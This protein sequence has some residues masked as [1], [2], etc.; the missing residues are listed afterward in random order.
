MSLSTKDTA[1]FSVIENTGQ[2]ISQGESNQGEVFT[3]TYNLIV[4]SGPPTWSPRPEPEL[5][6]VVLNNK[7]LGTRFNNSY[8]KIIEDYRVWYLKH[9][10]GRTVKQA[11]EFLRTN[12]ADIENF[13]CTAD[14]IMCSD[15]NYDK[16]GFVRTK[17]ITAKINSSANGS[18]GSTFVLDG[19][20]VTVRTA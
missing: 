15:W 2:L 11:S 5:T 4:I 12:P 19:Q 14:S 16:N 7:K 1:K 18:L 3:E 10:P 6:T 8:L 13:S 20:N 17:V 9:C